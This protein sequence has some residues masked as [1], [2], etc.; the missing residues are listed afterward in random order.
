MVVSF[1]CCIFVIEKENNKKQ[2][3]MKHRVDTEKE[4]TCSSGK[5]GYKSKRAAERAIKCIQANSKSERFRAYY[6][7]ECGR[8]H[9]TSC[10]VIEYRM[11]MKSF[12]QY[13]R[14]EKKSQDLMIL[15][16]YGLA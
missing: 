10:H 4:I 8:Y 14:L 7:K 2:H 13:N 3:I 15:Q 11:L 12:T 9:L 5:V 6:C 16:S 1:F